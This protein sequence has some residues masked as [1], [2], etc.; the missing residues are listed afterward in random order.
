MLCIYLWSPSGPVKHTSFKKS[1]SPFL[2][3]PRPGP[4][5]LSGQGCWGGRRGEKRRCEASR[6]KISSL[7]IDTEGVSWENLH[8]P[9]GVK[10]GCERTSCRGSAKCWRGGEWATCCELVFYTCHSYMF[11]HLWVWSLG[12]GGLCACF[13]VWHRDKSRV[14]GCPARGQ[15]GGVAQ[16]GGHGTAQCCRARRLEQCPVGRGSGS[17][18]ERPSALA[19]GRPR[20]PGNRRDLHLH[21]GLRGSPPAT[22]DRREPQTSMGR[23]PQRTK[24][25]FLWGCK[26]AFH[27][28]FRKGL[29]FLG[30]R[31][32]KEMLI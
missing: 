13:L 5:R 7:T 29:C 14:L 17:H 4:F 26:V 28:T 22:G 10:K 31:R 11:M 12:D 21:G 20:A 24:H 16:Q 1:Q 3:T 18:T 9:L 8:Y 27:G 23:C 32:G 30:R 2:V 19:W 6:A 15:H 25:L